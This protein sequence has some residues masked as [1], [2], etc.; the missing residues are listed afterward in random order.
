MNFDCPLDVSHFF[1]SFAGSRR[2]ITIC[3]HIAQSA[4]ID[5]YCKENQNKKKEH[6]SK[7]P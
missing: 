3:I 4:T 5:K 1:P 6:K 2:S 7:T